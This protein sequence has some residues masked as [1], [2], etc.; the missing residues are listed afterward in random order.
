MGPTSHLCFGR[1]S[2]QSTVL[3]DQSTVLSD[4]SRP[5]AAESLRRLA[6]RWSGAGATG[7]WPTSRLCSTVSSWAPGKVSTPDH[8]FEQIAKLNW[9]SCKPNMHLWFLW[10]CKCHFCDPS[11]GLNQQWVLWLAASLNFEVLNFWGAAA[12][13]LA[14][15]S[16]EE[17]KHA[18]KVVTE[19]DM[20]GR[21]SIIRW[22]KGSKGGKAI[23]ISKGF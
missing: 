13:F 15:D 22:V 4:Q 23:R 11:W 14:E 19:R 3:S 12:G 8:S 5:L 20:M 16:W 18:N 6:G 17:V 1:A 7:R 9:K 21:G 10:Y 2:A